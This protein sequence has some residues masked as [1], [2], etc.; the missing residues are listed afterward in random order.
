LTSRR[1]SSIV[2]MVA[3]FGVTVAAT[4]GC[5]SPPAAPES[6]YILVLDE[7]KAAVPDTEIVTHGEVVTKTN[8]DGRAELQLT[9]RE[10]TSFAVEV[11]CP[12]G[13][14]SVGPPLVIRRLMTVGSPVPEYSAHCGRLRHSVSVRIH[15]ENGSNMAVRH[16][17]KEVARTD[18]TGIAQ[19]VIEGMVHDRVDLTID[20]SDP[21]WAKVHPQNP[22]ATF[23]IT[24]KD[25]TQAF[26]VKFTAPPKP[27]RHVAQRTGPKAF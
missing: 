2:S 23:E 5:S 18:N 6:V 4:V 10:G 27:V 21:R 19:V 1:L 16:L 22:V 20:T 3:A 7:G 14:R 11:R 25:D 24:E 12:N 26:E 15:T 17:G 8:A 9:G 13:Y